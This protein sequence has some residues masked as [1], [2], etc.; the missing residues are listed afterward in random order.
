MRRRLD[1]AAALVHRPPVLFLDEPTTGLDP[2]RRNDLWAVLTE[3]VADGMT[4]LLTTQYL[5]EAEHLAGRI[6][7]IDGGSVIADGTPAELKQ[8]VGNTIIEVRLADAAAAER[9][10]GH[11]EP[12]GPS[13]VLDDG[14]TVAVTV[15]NPGRALAEV[16]RTLDGLGL[17]P[18]WLTVREP[19]LDDVFLQLTGRKAE[20][21][22]AEEAEQGAA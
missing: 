2:R 13:E 15:A 22:P 20:P 6:M 3:L 14:R 9:A 18:D 16:V 1:L 8:Q 19:T 12:V 5:E 21:P 17:S 7:V 11:L 4:L 10:R